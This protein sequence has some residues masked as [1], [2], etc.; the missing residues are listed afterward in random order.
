MTHLLRWLALLGVSLL[1]IPA[2]AQTAV[3]LLSPDAVGTVGGYNA[4][5]PGDSVTAIDVA[6]SG[7]DRAL[8]V[9]RGTAGV[10]AYDAILAWETHAPVARGDLVVASFSIRSR[11]AAGTPLRLEVTFQQGAAPYEQSL[12]AN[13]PVDTASWQR[14]AI[15]FRADRDYPT[16]TGTLQ[17]RYAAAVQQFEIGGIAATDYGAVATIPPALVDSFAFYYPGRGDANAPWRKAALAVIESERKTDLTVRVVDAAG[18]PVPG[19]KVSVSLVTPDFNWSSAVGARTLTC[20]TKPGAARGCDTLTENDR[21]TYRANALA[22]FTGLSL[23]NDLKWPDWESDRKLALDAI[24][25]IERSKRRFTRGHNLIWPSFQPDY[26]LPGDVTPTT[27]G[28]VLAARVLSHIAEELAATKG[29]IPEWDVVNEP[30][31][32]YDIQGRIAAPG[33]AEVP[34]LLPHS[35]VADWFKA[36]AIGDPAA[37][38]FLNDFAIFDNLDPF[39]R[40][41][42]LALLRFIQAQGGR[43]D[44]LGFQGHFGTSGPVFGDMADSLQQFDPLVG[45]YAL[46]EFDTMAIDPRLQADVMRDV[47][48]FV[49]G[50]PKFTGFQM[51]GFWDGDHWLG[52]GP[53]FT[54]DW[55]LKPSGVVW[56]VLRQQWSTKATLRADAAGAAQSRV[57]KGLYEFRIAGPGGKT[58]KTRETVVTPTTVTITPLC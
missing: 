31:D 26:K 43:V 48:T 32:N 41:Y 12:S 7:F 38:L 3:P 17:I 35:A 33:L 24:T 16:G 6:G 1:T 42:D 13:A 15:P 36:A 39:H 37:K 8:Q 29:R 52:A 22:E 14:Y 51:W 47:M 2:T 57:F 27:P 45:R 58:C 20:S 21:A 55:Q 11:G 46:T 54:R 30:Y 9:T 56:R 40:A 28:N 19:A 25:S 49:F 23:Y 53:L 5:A 34:G 10:H 44:G 50:S 4:G 18:Q